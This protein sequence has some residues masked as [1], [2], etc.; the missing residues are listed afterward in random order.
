ME[1]RKE[2]VM[3]GLI[4]QNGYELENRVHFRG[5]VALHKEQAER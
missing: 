1:K 2:I 4:N 3:L 5:G